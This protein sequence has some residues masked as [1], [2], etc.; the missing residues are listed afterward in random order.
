M[1]SMPVFQK[2]EEIRELTR[3]IIDSI[4]DERVRMMY[5]NTMLEDSI[6]IPDRI[7]AAEA[8]DDYIAKMENATV[9][10]IHARSLLAQSESLVFEGALPKEYL[11]LLQKELKTFRELFRSWIKSFKN[12]E[13]KDDGWGLF[14]D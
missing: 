10:K 2:A 4:H 11:V 3:S 13:R 5:T 12:A 6:I 14:L 1:D 8:M 9:V 7:A